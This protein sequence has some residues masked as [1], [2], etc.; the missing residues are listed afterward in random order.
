M[1]AL[2]TCDC[3]LFIVEGIICRH[4]FVT[5]RINQIHTLSKYVYPRWRVKLFPEKKMHNFSAN[6]V[7]EAKKM[8]NDIIKI[9]ENEAEKKVAFASFLSGAR[10]KKET[11]VRKSSRQTRSEEDS[12]HI[13]LGKNLTLEIESEKE[14]DIKNFKKN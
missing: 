5:A 9:E 14:L 1:K 4:M 8:D 13:E 11:D 2:F 10:K 12:I 6:V 3:E 7:K